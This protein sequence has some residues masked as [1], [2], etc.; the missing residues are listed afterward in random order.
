MQDM[1]VSLVF[2]HPLEKL[3]TILMSYALGTILGQP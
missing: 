2:F 1:F 3:A